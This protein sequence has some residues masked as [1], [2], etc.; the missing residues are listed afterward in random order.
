MRYMSMHIIINRQHEKMVQLIRPL[1]SLDSE[2]TAGLHHELTDLGHG[3]DPE[4][5]LRSIGKA[6]C[7]LFEE[8]HARA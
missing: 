7:Q 4:M 1:P 2:K 3:T 6:G 8:G 5:M